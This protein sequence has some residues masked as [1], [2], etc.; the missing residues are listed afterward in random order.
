MA[1]R[2][3]KEDCPS[4]LAEK[5]G[6]D[7]EIL[8][9]RSEIEKERVRKNLCPKCEA[10]KAPKISAEVSNFLREVDLCLRFRCL[11]YS[12]SLQDQPVGWLI[13]ALLVARM[14]DN[15]VRRND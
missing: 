12:G 9:L 7:G 10:N 3:T 6:V 2:K 4:C 8:G 15:Y 14:R 5:K 1:G 11:P 13:K